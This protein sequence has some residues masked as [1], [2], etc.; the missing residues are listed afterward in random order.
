ML[1]CIESHL[2]LSFSLGSDDKCFG[3]S[4]YTFSES[5]KKWSQNRITCQRKGGDLVS[6]ETEKEWQ[7]INTEIQKLCIG[8]PNEWHIGLHKVGDVWKWVNGKPLTI[9]KWQNNQPSGD[10]DVAVMSKDFPPTKQ[11]LFNDL[12]DRL[13]RAYICEMPKGKNTRNERSTRHLLLH[14]LIESYVWW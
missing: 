12:E 7:F 1:I 8:V 14:M 11:G 4:C 6:I 2:S 10:G 13:Y 3:K 9:S 5:G